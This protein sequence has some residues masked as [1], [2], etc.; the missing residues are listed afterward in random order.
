MTARDTT[1]QALAQERGESDESVSTLESTVAARDAEIVRLKQQNAALQA[2]LDALKNPPTPSDAWPTSMKLGAAEGDYTGLSADVG[3]PFKVK[4]LYDNTLPANVANCKAK[5]VMDAG[6][7]PWISF[8]STAQP[9]A[10]TLSSFKASV[11]KPIIVTPVHECD[12]GPKMDPAAYGKMLDTW[13]QAFKDNPNIKVGPI[14]MAT[15]Y[16]NGSHVQYMPVNCHVIGV[17]GYRFQR[18]PGSPPSPKTGSLGQNREAEWIFSGA[19]DEAKKRGVKLGIG[20][21]SAHD[22]VDLAERAGWFDRTFTW[23]K[24][25]NTIT[26]CLFSSGAGEDGPWWP[27]YRHIFKGQTV[28]GVAG[29]AKG[30]HDPNTV[31]VLKKWNV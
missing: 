13:Y 1:N 27:N 5:A 24:N 26:T 22:M 14:L 28:G 9:S 2:E 10:A 12:N 21:V 30:E 11:T 31:A 7:I 16:R 8:S 18:K 25:N 3:A 29:P 4:R 17:D 23:A 19:R 15:T 20:E 6:N